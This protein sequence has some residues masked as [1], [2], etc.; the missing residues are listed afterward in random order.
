MEQL[1]PLAAGM[2]AYNSSKTWGM[3][4]YKG[5][6]IDMAIGKDNADAIREA[7]RRD[8]IDHN[9]RT[10][11]GDSLRRLAKR[12]NAEKVEVALAELGYPE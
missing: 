2:P 12:K 4:G 8:W 10:F 9:T 1:T 6:Q 11:M 5:M 3:F 7:H